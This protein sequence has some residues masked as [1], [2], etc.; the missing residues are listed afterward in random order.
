[1][2]ETRERFDVAIAGGSF[3]G[4]AQA[5]ALA[6]ADASIRVAVIDRTPPD[7]AGTARADGRA[8]ALSAASRQLLD[9]LGVWDEV[10]ANAQPIVDIEITD[11]SLDTVV[12]P[13]LLHFDTEAQAR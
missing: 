2:A 13:R 1:M 7:V 11:S 4:L 6:R 5:L 8:T 12:R 3:V 9:V 10:D